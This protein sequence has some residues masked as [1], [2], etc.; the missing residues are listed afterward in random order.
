MKM[1]PHRR[2]GFLVR[3]VARLYS[4]HFDRLARQ[5]LGLSLAQCR[6]LG[7]IALHKGAHPPSQAELAEK[8]DL[9]P[10]GVARLCDRMQSAKWI[11]RQP[12]ST[13]RRTNHI[14]L[15]PRARKALEDALA[16]GD[17]LQSAAF[18]GLKPAQQKA[19]LEALRQA[20][21]NLTAL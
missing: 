4:W 19:L 7:A 10:M 17:Q 3:D 13:D 5:K 20:H 21:S 12:S 15:L 16:L 1:D 2:F 11:A 9:T 18:K 8:L 14:A 6:L